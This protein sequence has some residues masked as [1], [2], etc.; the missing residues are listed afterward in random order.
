RTGP[1]SIGPNLRRGTGPKPSRQK[2]R[3]VAEA[4]ASLLPATG[5]LD[6]DPRR[7]EYAPRGRAVIDHVESGRLQ[8][9][10]VQG[11]VDAQCARDQPWTAAPSDARA[12]LQGADQHRLGHAFLTRDEVEAPVH[13]V[14]EVDVGMPWGAEHHL[15]A[16]RPPPAPRV[17]G[18]VV[19][20]EV[21]L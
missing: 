2:R 1:T 21:R 7:G 19:R 9:D 13:S 17:G 16:R 4:Q 14:C 6:A 5:A 20:P 8:P 10:A 11:A 18:E 12:R 15:R 3:V